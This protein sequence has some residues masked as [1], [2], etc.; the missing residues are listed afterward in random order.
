MSDLDQNKGGHEGPEGLRVR[1][2]A[3]TPGELRADGAVASSDVRADAQGLAMLSSSQ[4]AL[5]PLTADGRAG[6]A[7]PARPGASPRVPGARPKVPGQANAPQPDPEVDGAPVEA[8]SHSDPAAELRI[9]S[10]AS[11]PGDLTAGAP[12][13][14]Q[15]PDPA[16]LPTI[17]ATAE[18][19]RERATDDEVEDGPSLLETL[20]TQAGE[21]AGEH[22]PDLAGA[23]PEAARGL[24]GA[25]GR[26]LRELG[27]AAVRVGED[28]AGRSSDQIEDSTNRSVD[29]TV[30][31][32]S[33]DAL[34]R[35]AQAVRQAHDALPAPR[36]ARRLEGWESAAMRQDLR[37]ERQA[38]KALRAD[39]RANAMVRDGA[40]ADG[41]LV[42]H[43]RRVA[44]RARAAQRSRAAAAARLRGQ[45]TGIRG[46]LQRLRVGWA[47]GV[48]GAL[49]LR[50]LGIVAAAVAVALAAPVA[51]ST[52]ASSAM[53][54]VAGGSSQSS[55]SLTGV[56]A[57]VARALRAAGLTNVQIAAVLGNLHAES[58]MDPTAYAI[59]DGSSFPYER[60]LGLFQFT[61]AGNG[62][63]DLTE[64]SEL[65]N[66]LSWC[67]AN[68]R[69]SV[70]AGAQTEYWVT[71]YRPNWGTALHEHGY[72][73]AACPEYADADCSLEAW[74]ECTDVGLATYMFM[75]CSGR[76]AAW[77]ARFDVRLQAALEAYAALQ[78]GSLE[79]GQEYEAANETQR[80]IADAATRTPSPGPSL[81][82]A[83]VSN[84]YANA[85]LGRVGG[86]AND[87]YASWCHSSD[88][89]E[90]QVGM[91][92]AVAPSD[93][94][95]MG[96]IYGHV[97]IYVGD[98]MV[99]HCTNDT[100]FK[101]TLDEWI[102][103]YG[104]YAQV[105]WGYPANVA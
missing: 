17:A 69:S 2:R 91:L 26:A 51:L 23:A 43:E 55:G 71:T 65:S 74:D 31:Q 16:E 29:S 6:A 15:G 103:T 35:D 58:G 5:S 93:A 89:S 88:R 36:A 10:G 61:D 87:M 37:A 82:A 81:C 28:S 57:L 98:G 83:W 62:P 72:Y 18:R 12:D 85:G 38:A 9:D 104:R 46:A 79:G 22:A 44:E 39:L 19:A 84:V 50:T 75:A 99:M 63:D 49:G 70:D 86:N 77:A 25:G 4:D 24:I 14:A 90:L 59:F 21:V 78:S 13:Q 48:R 94:S 64:V 1:R 54:I 42:K 73:A 52:C 3:E 32:A 20:R 66:F 95:G 67:A 27:R 11:S 33:P 45:G 41:L 102:G 34:R 92:V 105:R 30:A 7:G 101:C 96:A 47:Q 56:D 80:A 76:P 68:G 100:V 97:G 60:A 8:P 40:P 53:V